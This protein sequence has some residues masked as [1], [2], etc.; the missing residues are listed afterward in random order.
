LEEVGLE[1]TQKTAKTTTYEH[2]VLI[3]HSCHER[4]IYINPCGIDTLKIFCSQIFDIKKINKKGYFIVP[5]PKGMYNIIRI[6]D[7]Y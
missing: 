2:I 5:S 6:P 4:R 3:W 1:P 7:I